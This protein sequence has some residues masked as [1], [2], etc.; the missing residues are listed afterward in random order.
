MWCMIAD[1]MIGFKHLG[2]THTHTHTHTRAE[3]EAR[4]HGAETQ[5]WLQCEQSAER[6]CMI[7]NAVNLLK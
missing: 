4:T 6:C 5:T 2:V 7:A 3:R 1:A